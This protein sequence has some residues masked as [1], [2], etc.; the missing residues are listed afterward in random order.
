MSATTAAAPDATTP[1]RQIRW[2]LAAPPQVLLALL[3]TAVVSVVVLAVSELAAGRVNET[4][5]EAVDLR[6]RA[7]HVSE[8]RQ[9]LV[10]AESGQRGYLLTQDQRYLQPMK[11]AAA[12]AEKA[13]VS[14]QASSLSDRSALQ[15]SVDIVSLG[16]RKLDELRITVTQAEQG[17]LDL[18]MTLLKGGF[19]VQLMEDLVARCNAF[20]TQQLTAL[21]DKEGAIS[22]SLLQQRFGVGIVVLINL[23]FLALLANM[24]IRQF[25]LREEHRAELERQAGLLEQTVNE[26]T[27]EL[28]AL[29]TY[30]QTS[31]EREKAR[32]ARDLHDELGGILTSAKIDIGWLE[33]HSKATD[34][35]VVPRLQR[36]A[37]VLDEAVDLKRRVVENLRPSLLDHLGLGAALTWYVNETCRKANLKCGLRM[38][39][40]N[41]AVPAEMAIAIYRLVQEGLNNC[42]KYAQADEV[43]I[44]VERAHNGYRL[45]LSDNGVGIHD[46]RAE[47]L[48]HGIAGMRQRARALGGRFELRT[49]PGQGTTIEAFFPLAEPVARI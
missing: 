14:L 19:G 46:F 20:E 9:A 13:F 6:E 2:F 26:R 10:Q 1:L 38:L 29:S 33:G 30:L 42:I 47:H 23:G 43:N 12:R 37:K 48:S 36:L 8:L 45:R 5:A 4:R 21:R 3:L 31:S 15:R 35:E 11:D 17:R 7:T 24:M 22:T 27:E 28:S 41:E 40:D 18:A 16:N 39:D 49:S 44:T 25:T 34:P 32:L